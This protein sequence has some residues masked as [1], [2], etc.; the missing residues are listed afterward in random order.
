MNSKLLLIP[1]LGAVVLLGLLCGNFMAFTLDISPALQ[2]LDATA[3]IQFQQQLNQTVSNKG[4]AVL[5]FGATL[6][7]F[8]SA[9]FAAW[10]SHRPLAMYWLVVA[11]LHFIG[12]YW[13]TVV[14]NIPLHQE[15]LAWNPLAPPADWQSTRDSWANSN[16]IRT[17][18]ELA[19]FSG[20]LML[21]A[22]RGKIAAQPVY[23]MR[24]QH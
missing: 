8:L 23:V 16:L 14:T 24:R 17:C 9:G 1:Q 12:V 3:Y 4:F 20:A 11:L 6:F 7:P 5:F 13:V 15:M 10:Q 2:R 19:C 22:L 21:V 18:V